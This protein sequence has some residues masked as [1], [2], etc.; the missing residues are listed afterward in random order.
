MEVK[1]IRNK[2][3]EIHRLNP[4]FQTW[5]TEG[6]NTLVD[7]SIK[8]TLIKVENLI[9]ELLPK[10]YEDGAAEFARQLKFALHE[11]VEVSA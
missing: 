10:Y 5:D 1:D 4:N 8:L 6:I 11:N 2:S 3:W 9:D 7:I